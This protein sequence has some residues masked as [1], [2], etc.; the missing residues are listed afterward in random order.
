MAKN[1]A[2]KIGEKISRKE[3]VKR[4][5]TLFMTLP[6]GNEVLSRDYIKIMWDPQKEEVVHLFTAA[7][8]YRRF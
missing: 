3:L 6:N 7:D 1:I 2:L 8:T 5:W 4:G